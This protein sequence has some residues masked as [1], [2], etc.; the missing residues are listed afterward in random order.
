MVGRYFSGCLISAL[1]FSC[2]P[3]EKE[4]EHPKPEPAAPIVVVKPR[5]EVLTEEQKTE[6][7]LHPDLVP[8]L[9]M[10]A[11]SQAEPFFI[12]VVMPS[13]NLKGEKG[14]E[15]EKL[16]GFSLRTK[17][18]EELITSYRAGLRVRGYLIFRSHKSYGTLPDIVTVVK[19]NNSYDILK[20]QGTEALNYHLD[21]P[22]IIKWLKAQ[23]QL[24]SFVITGA[25][26]DW[27]EAKFVKQPANMRAFARKAS[28][29]AP[30]VLGHGR[31][32]ADKLAEKMKRMNGFY[33]EWE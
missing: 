10:S 29:F 4:A 19:G 12:S 23:Q 28:A 22:D 15:K 9:E 1:V 31:M 11:G 13:E 30:D 16:A 21:T 20:I 6:L 18:A 27:L 32:T 33:L 24:G 2:S 7:R 26:P 3:A 5:H 17:N 25:G 14:F 8:K